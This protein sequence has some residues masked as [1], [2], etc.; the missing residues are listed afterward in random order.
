MGIDWMKL[1]RGR[2][3]SPSAPAPIVGEVL[4]VAP[5]DNRWGK[6]F[7]FLDFKAGR[8][9]GHI[10][11]LGEGDLLAHEMQSGKTAVLRVVKLERCSDPADMFF[12]EVE[13]IGYSDDLP[14]VTLPSPRR[15]ALWPLG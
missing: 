9:W 4:H 14:R 5:R 15:S 7:E 8:I 10:L 2:L 11:H 13:T 6:H 12:G 1:L 3:R